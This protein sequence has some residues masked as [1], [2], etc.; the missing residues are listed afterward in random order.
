[1]PVLINQPHELRVT[2]Q[3][4][5]HAASTVILQ[6]VL[7]PSASVS[8]LRG[9]AVSA[10]KTVFGV[11]ISRNDFKFLSV[12]INEEF[13]RVRAFSEPA[14]LVTFSL[15]KRAESCQFIALFIRGGDALACH[16]A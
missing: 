5:I 2:L 10:E 1:M 9:V 16:L 14:E 11:F 8:S 7:A 15:D 4:S 6:R 12:S 13:F 3:V